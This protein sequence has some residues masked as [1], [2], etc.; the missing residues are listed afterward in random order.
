MSKPPV[1]DLEGFSVITVHSIQPSMAMVTE[2]KQIQR[3]VPSVIILAEKLVGVSPCLGPSASV[4][5]R[6]SLPPGSVLPIPLQTLQSFDW[7]CT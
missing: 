6:H 2:L 1:L 4:G 7:I 3:W 5:S